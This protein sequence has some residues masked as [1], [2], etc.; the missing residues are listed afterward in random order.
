MPDVNRCHTRTVD[1][2]LLIS[3]VNDLASLDAGQEAFRNHLAAA[4]VS[5]RA[6]YHSELAFE[7][8]VTNVMRHGYADMVSGSRAI[9][10]SVCI[11]MARF[12]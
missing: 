8:L 10:I 2:C 12:V 1:G 11:P 3:I 9:D 6:A 5:E 4:G 7:E